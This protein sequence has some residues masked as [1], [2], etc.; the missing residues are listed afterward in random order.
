MIGSGVGG[1]ELIMVDFRKRI[2]DQRKDGRTDPLVGARIL[3]RNANEN[4]GVN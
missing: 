1:I 3:T 2:T 4:I